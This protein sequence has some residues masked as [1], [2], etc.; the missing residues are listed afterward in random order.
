MVCACVQLAQIRG[1]LRGRLSEEEARRGEVEGQLQ[2]RRGLLREGL[3]TLAQGAYRG[4]LPYEAAEKGP[5]VSFE[6]A[7]ELLEPG[8]EDCVNGGE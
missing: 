2:A 8:G 1:A 6:A 3:C 5:G 4:T 7:L